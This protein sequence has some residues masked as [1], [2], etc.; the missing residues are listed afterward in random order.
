MDEW[1]SLSLK[2]EQER[3]VFKHVSN[4]TLSRQRRLSLQQEKINMEKGGK[5]VSRREKGILV[6]TN[7]D[8]KSK[9]TRTE[10]LHVGLAKERSLMTLDLFF[11][12]DH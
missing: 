10:K 11:L 6:R 9:E 1:D 7:V 3:S 12:V 8:E 4:E 5:N 2:C